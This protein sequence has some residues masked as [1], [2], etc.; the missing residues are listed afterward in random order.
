MGSHHQQRG[1]RSLCMGRK[2]TPVVDIPKIHCHEDIFDG[3]SSRAS[4]S[5]VVEAS[6]SPSAL[7]GP[8][9]PSSPRPSPPESSVDVRIQADLLR[10]PRIRRRRYTD[11]QLTLSKDFLAMRTFDLYTPDQVLKSK[12]NVKAT[13][14]EDYKDDDHDDYLAFPHAQ[15]V[16]QT[17]PTAKAKAFENIPKASEA[18]QQAME[19]LKSR[20][21]SSS[22]S[23]TDSMPSDDSRLGSV[24]KFEHQPPPVITISSFDVHNL[25]NAPHE[26]MLATNEDAVEH[27]SHFT[28][29]SLTNCH[30]SLATEDLSNDTEEISLRGRKTKSLRRVK[31]AFGVCHK[32]STQNQKE[33][34]QISNV[35]HGSKGNSERKDPKQAPSSKNKQKSNAEKP[36]KSI[37]PNRRSTSE[38]KTRHCVRTSP[39][40]PRN[41]LG[42]TSRPVLSSS[43][44]TVPRRASLP[45]GMRRAVHQNLLSTPENTANKSSSSHGTSRQDPSNSPK[46]DHHLGSLSWPSSSPCSSDSQASSPHLRSRLQSH[47]LRPARS[48]QDIT[49]SAITLKTAGQITRFITANAASSTKPGVN[50]RQHVMPDALTL[51]PVLAHSGRLL[52]RRRDDSLRL[53]KQAVITDSE[54]ADDGV[55]AIKQTADE[56]RYFRNKR[57][58]KSLLGFSEI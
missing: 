28:P 22:N 47:P 12:S 5:S 38:S 10:S 51:P 43:P 42:N 19:D 56:R 24:N 31:S 55:F 30:E 8:R 41:H 9:P 33:T 58:S 50:K 25:E 6:T 29:A 21:Q 15:P 18:F 53:V 45:V 40:P 57:Q 3:S 16:R 34:Q 39:S 44:P 2:A 23:S 35:K 26:V 48:W 11:C 37:S 20:P 52:P 13:N 46:D 36:T 54:M 7:L 32:S 49:S 1:D 4:S 17:L 14:E 27:N